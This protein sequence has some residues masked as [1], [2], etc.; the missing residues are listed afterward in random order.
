[1]TRSAEIALL[2]EELRG[3]GTFDPRIEAGIGT[4]V[5]KPSCLAQS[6][7]RR[8]AWKLAPSAHLHGYLILSWKRWPNQMKC[9]SFL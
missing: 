1:M 8:G 7:V 3:K 6:H 4:Y 9:L 2:S 5:E